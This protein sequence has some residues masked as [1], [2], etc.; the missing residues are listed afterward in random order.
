MALVAATLQVHEW[1]KRGIMSGIE[2]RPEQ[3]P[4][5]RQLTEPRTQVLNLEMNN[6]GLICYIPVCAINLISSIVFLATEPKTNTFLRFHAWQSLLLTAAYVIIGVVINTVGAFLAAIPF[7]RWL[8]FIPFAAWLVV[9]V[10]YIWKSIAMGLYARKG[11]IERLPV[12]G[13]V[14]D[15]L[16]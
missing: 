1:L 8:G 2:N 12:I 14:A 9:S 4:D 16:P 6:A 13:E 5:P 7:L 10:V 15:R 11:G 3:Q